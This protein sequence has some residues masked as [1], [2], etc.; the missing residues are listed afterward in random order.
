[1]MLLISP[2]GGEGTLLFAAVLALAAAAAF[3]WRR[4]ER[5]VAVAGTLGD[6]L[7]RQ[8]G[9][10]EYT[11][12]SP[13]SR[14]DISSSPAMASSDLMLDL[15]NKPWPIKWIS[16]DGAASTSMVHGVSE[17]EMAELR[18]DPVVRPSW[19]GRASSLPK[20]DA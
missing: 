9:K 4:S 2:L 11:G 17:E 3:A 14:T 15:F 1:M 19:I 13:I 20:S 16:A 12:W 10:I 6:V 7:Y 5:L 18:K 8:G